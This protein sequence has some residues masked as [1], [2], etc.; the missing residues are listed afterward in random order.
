MLADGGCITGVEVRRRDGCGGG[1]GESDRGVRVLCILRGCMREQPPVLAAPAAAAS[2][3]ERLLLAACLPCLFN[4]MAAVRVCLL[5]G[6]FVWQGP[7]SARSMPAE[8]ANPIPNV[9]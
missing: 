8:R 9:I 3:L 4:E 2:G 1:R 6:T 7:G 5:V